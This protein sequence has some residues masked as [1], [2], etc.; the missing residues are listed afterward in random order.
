MKKIP[1]VEIILGRVEKTLHPF[2]ANQ[3]KKI[4]F[5]NID[6]DVYEPVAYVL[7]EIKSYVQPG[8]LIVFDELIGYPGWE[9]HEKKAIYEYFSGLSY[10]WLAFS[11][12]QAIMRIK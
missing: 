2:L 3:N 11:D 4:A 7:K 12:L 1:G 10:E 9:N 6:L 5:V 8:T